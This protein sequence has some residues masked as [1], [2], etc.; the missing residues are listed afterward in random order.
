MCSVF[1]GQTWYSLFDFTADG[2]KLRLAAV[3]RLPV[4]HHGAVFIFG[5]LP[6][7]YLRRL[8]HFIGCRRDC[9]PAKP[10]CY[11]TKCFN[12]IMTPIYVLLFVW[13]FQGQPLRLYL[14]SLQLMLSTVWRPWKS[15]RTS[16][17]CSFYFF[18]ISY[19]PFWY[20]REKL[21]S[22]LAG[23]SGS[24]GGWRMLPGKY[25]AAM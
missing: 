22:T 23:D 13:Y 8:S 10:F 3:K 5:L 7:W 25:L 24:G 12:E 21:N 9:N 20:L 1:Q 11:H 14:L 17:W 2:F 15:P 18:S 6:C 4:L 19:S 16:L